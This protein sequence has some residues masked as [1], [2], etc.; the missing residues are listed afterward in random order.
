MGFIKKNVLYIAWATAFVAMLGSLFFS[1]VLNYPPC[2]L[3]WYQRIALF[4]TFFI[5]TVGILIKDV[6]VYLYVLPLTVIGLGVS[7]YHNLLYYKILPEALAPCVAGI[8]CTT[9]Y[10][11]WFGFVTIP[12]LSLIALTI[13][14]IC[15]WVYRSIQNEQRT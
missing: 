11:N 7:I 13:I 4:S 12:L 15:M 8:S 14:T 1:E 5:L 10:I 2:V 6:K 3:C 9:K